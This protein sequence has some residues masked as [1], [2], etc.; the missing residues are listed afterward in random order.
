MSVDPRAEK[1]NIVINDHGRTQKCNFSFLDCKYPQIR[2]VNLCLNSI[3][4][5]ILICR[6]QWWC[7]FFHFRPEI[8]FLEKFGPKIHCLKWN[9]AP[10]LIRNVALSG[11]VHFLCFRPEIFFCANLVQKVKI[12]RLSWNLVPRLIRI[13]RI[14]WWCSLFPFLPGIAFFGQ[15]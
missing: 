14:Q 10:R 6:I 12:V 5:L 2:I 15:I 8:L 13:C 7:H 4:R 3:S 9:L 1:F 11:D